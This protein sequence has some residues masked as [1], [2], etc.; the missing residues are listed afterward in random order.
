M[1]LEKQDFRGNVQFSLFLFRDSG[2]VVR[3]GLKAGRGWENSKVFGGG[4]S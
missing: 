1:M 4:L 3:C 2:G